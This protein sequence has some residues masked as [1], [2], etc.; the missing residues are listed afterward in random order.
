MCRF[1]G[2]SPKEKISKAFARKK[3]IAGLRTVTAYAPGPSRCEEAQTPLGRKWKDGSGGWL[4]NKGTGCE[5][6]RAQLMSRKV[7][8]SPQR[9]P[10]SFMCDGMGGSIKLKN[11]IYNFSDI[12]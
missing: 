1:L 10:I 7:G 9:T 5:R 4:C 8:G 11:I 2:L 6:T 3:N 12:K